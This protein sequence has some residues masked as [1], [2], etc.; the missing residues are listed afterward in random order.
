MSS[1]A[2][3][4]VGGGGGMANIQTLTGNTGG[5]VGPTANN[6]NIVGSGFITVTGNPG[7]STLT[8]S[9][10]N[11]N[12]ATAT[13][14]GATPVNIISL[15]VA[16]SQMV[17]ITAVINGIQDDFSDCWGGDLIFT[18]YRPAGGDVTVVGGIIANANTTSTADVSG[19]VNIGTEMAEINVIGVAAET[20]NWSASYQFFYQP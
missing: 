5:P 16:D 4:T 12:D 7:T 15:P 20:W 3:F 17:T 9:Q 8:I 18:V 10:S 2:Q 6:V 14:I 1:S 11:S 13:T 19:T